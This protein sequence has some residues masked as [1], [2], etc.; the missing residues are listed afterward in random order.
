MLPATFG[1]FGCLLVDVK[2]ALLVVSLGLVVPLLPS[3]T[4][5]VQFF[6]L[7]LLNC[8]L[9]IQK[10]IEKVYAIELVFDLFHHLKVASHISVCWICTV[11]NLYLGI[12]LIPFGLEISVLCLPKLLQSSS[13]Y[14][15]DV[16]AVHSKNC[17]VIVLT[18]EGLPN[19]I[20][21]ANLKPTKRKHKH[22]PLLYFGGSLVV[23]PSLRLN[24][25]L[26]GTNY[27]DCTKLLLGAPV[28]IEE[29]LHS[30][31]L[32]QLKTHLL[33]I[34]QIVFLLIRPGI[35]GGIGVYTHSKNHL[36]WSLP[37]FDTTLLRTYH[38]GHHHSQR[39]TFH[40]ECTSCAYSF[41]D[42]RILQTES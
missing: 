28:F 23:L 25:C 11:E 15:E 37:L 1:V 19:S 8:P 31:Q 3:K 39:S 36:C 42:L 27:L 12:L 20:T 9:K 32:L 40:P 2:T 35:L 5:V 6:C 38:H 14:L 29:E 18:P 10:Q 13:T 22:I 16:T 17:Q 4:R 34:C 33:Q 41:S 30:L 21:R 7:L 26:K 24:W